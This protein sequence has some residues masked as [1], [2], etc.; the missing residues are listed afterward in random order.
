MVL[1]NGA[2][3]IGTGWSTKVPNFNPREIVENIRRLIRGEEL[4]PML[5]WYKHFRG[6][7][8]QLD[9][10]RYVCNG[11]VAKVSD[12]TIEVTELPIKTWTQKYK[13]SVIE[14][15]NEGSEKAKYAIQDFK[16][17][18]TEQ[19][20]KFLVK[21]QPDKLQA[22]ER[23]GLHT[24]FKLQTVIN[25]TSMVLFDAEGVLKRYNSPLEIVREF[26]D[27][28]KRIYIERKRFLEGKLGSESS[29]L[30]EQVRYPNRNLF[31]FRRASF[32]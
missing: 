16:E 15:M 6:S 24:V 9:G 3:G 19:T 10:S 4:K 1:V 7:I 31:E 30:S 22:A 32:S 18:H 8:V 26:F 11:E 27:A 12:D 13:E 23:D 29:R 21:M 28:R 20:V 5:P 2:E 14:P 25:T 17:Y